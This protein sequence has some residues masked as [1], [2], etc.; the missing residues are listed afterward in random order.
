MG[1][2]TPN[3]WMFCGD[4]LFSP[5][6]LL[7]F[8]ALWLAALPGLLALWLVLTPFWWLYPERHAHVHDAGGTP[9]QQEE[10]L[11]WRAELAQ[12]PFWKR[13]REKFSRAA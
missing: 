4:V 13:L 3:Q 12:K 8:L 2:P 9:E 10:L 6:A 11:R 1:E 5:A 7:G